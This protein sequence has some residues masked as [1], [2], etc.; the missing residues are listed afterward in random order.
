MPEISATVPPG[1]GLHARPAAMFVQAAAAAPMAV[2][3]GR[4]GGP[5]ADAKSILAVMGLGVKE[6]ETVILSAEGDQAHQVLA[7]LKVLLETPEG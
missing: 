7:D 6:G 4:A 3:V 5:A 2:T 1:V